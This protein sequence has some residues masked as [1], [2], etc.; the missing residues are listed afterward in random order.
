M[1]P[2]PNP[3]FYSNY[4]S[5]ERGELCLVLVVSLLSYTDLVTLSLVEKELVELIVSNGIRFNPDISLEVDS[6][7]FFFFNDVEG[8]TFKM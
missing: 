1:L 8:Q 7:I 3:N 6:T 4:R 5:V 2:R